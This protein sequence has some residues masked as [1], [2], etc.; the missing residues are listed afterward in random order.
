MAAR[1][2]TVKMG[3]GVLLFYG[4]GS[5]RGGGLVERHTGEKGVTGGGKMIGEK[6]TQRLCRNGVRKKGL[7]KCQGVKLP[8]DQKRPKV[9]LG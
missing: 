4:G 8:L 1:Q 9:K 3:R 2:S 7:A 6:S 5:G